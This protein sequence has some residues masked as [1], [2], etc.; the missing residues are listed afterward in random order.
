MGNLISSQFDET[1]Q[2]SSN[3]LLVFLDYVDEQSAA[4]EAANRLYAPNVH[5]RMSVELLRRHFQGKLTQPTLLIDV[6]GAPYATATRRLNELVDQGLIIR[7]AKS[8][9][10]RSFSLHPSDE[11][12]SLWAHMAKEHSLLI[13]ET[14][15]SQVEYNKSADRF[16]GSDY[17]DDRLGAPLNVLSKPLTLSGGLKVLSHSDPSFA[18]MTN[19][20]RH[21][22][23]IMGC[24]IHHRSFTLDKLYNEIVANASKDRSGYDLV[25]VNLPWI[26]EFAEKGMLQPLNDLMDIESLNPTDFHS[27]SWHAAHW[28]GECYGIPVETSCELLMYR[29]DLLAGEGLLPPTTTSSLLEAARKLHKPEE[30]QYGIAWNAARGTALGHTFMMAM[31]DFGQPIVDLD[32]YGDGFTLSKAGDRQYKSMINSPAGLAAA[33]FLKDLLQYSAPGILT[34]SWYERTKCFAE[35]SVAM[36]YGFSQMAAYFDR[37]EQSP[38]YGQTGYLPHPAGGALKPISPVGGFVLAVPSNVNPKRREDVLTALETFTSARAQNLY[39]KNGS[40]G[41]SRYSASEDPAL[42]AESPIIESID[43]LARSGQL[44]SW[45]RPQ[46]PE[47]AAITQICGVIMHEM[48]RGIIS[49]EEAI[50]RAHNDVVQILENWNQ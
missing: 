23:M 26:G 42:R 15:G 16:Y 5:M 44:Q 11:L 17:F 20:K 41:C 39:I 12:L 1:S 28:N 45:P 14:Y 36:A 37:D 40:L 9:S 47:I 25:A 49:P 6:S 38:A 18:V 21:F 29:T 30:K 3:E 22:E 8:K 19:L 10:E 35:G 4:F 13:K 46:I 2:S 43:M 34:M 31:A 33:N 7:R 50:N 48:L 32:P 24:P 27:S